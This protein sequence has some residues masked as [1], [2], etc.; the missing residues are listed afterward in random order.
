VKGT[1]LHV[2]YARYFTPPPVEYVSTADLAK[3]DNTTNAAATPISSQVRAERAHYFDAGITQSLTPSWSFG[4]DAY[5]K[6][7][8]NQID[9]GQFGQAVVFSTFNYD[10]GKVL[11][12]EFTTNYS[13]KGLSAYANL[14]IGR[15]TGKKFTSGEFFFSQDRVD[16]VSAYNVHLDHEQLYT[17]SSGVSYKIAHSLIYADALFGTGLRRGFANTDHLPSYTTVNLGFQ[18]DFPLQ[19]HQMI[20]LRL[21]VVNVFDKI[22][23]LRDGSGIGV[24]APQFGSR[25]GIYGGVTLSF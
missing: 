15:A 2:G 14:A 11:G 21:D 4:V 13:H 16:Y 18:Q 25:R 24:G 20:S 6:K 19:E 17:A 9:E 12:I 8:K 5:Y 10:T 3:F 23:E 22:Y 7:A 1:S